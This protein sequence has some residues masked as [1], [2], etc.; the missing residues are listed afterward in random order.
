MKQLVKVAAL[1]LVALMALPPFITPLASAGTY[2]YSHLTTFDGGDTT[3]VLSFQQAG[4]LQTGVTMDVNSAIF[5]A[6]VDAHPESY[7]PGGLDYPINPAIDIG[8]DG[9]N[10]WAYNGIGYGRWGLQD[11]F[12][13]NSSQTTL[14]FY[15]P[16]DTYDI[17]FKV[18]KDAD[19]IGGSF[20]TGGWPVPYW[21]PQRVVSDPNTKSPAENSPVLLVFRGLLFEAWVSEDSTVTNN[22]NADI[23]YRHFDGKNWSKAVDLSWPKDIYWDDSPQ[24]VTF[25]GKLYCM[26]SA[27]ES[28]DF[29]SND[30]IL[31][32][33]TSDGNNWSSIQKISP[34][35]R[36]GMN[37]WPSPVVFQDKLYIV[38][39]TLDP[40]IADITDS[41]DMDLVYRWWDGANLGPIAELTKN[42]DG[43]MDWSFSTCAFNNRLYVVWETDT[44]AGGFLGP[45]MDIVVKSFDGISWSNRK[46]LSPD[47]DDVKDEIPG[48][49]VWYNPVKGSDELW[50]IW[51]RG[52]GNP[53]G[54]GDINIVVRSFDGSSWTPMQEISQPGLQVQNMGQVLINYEGRLYAIWVDGTESVIVS[55]TS[56]LIVYKIYGNIDIRSYDGY[57]WSSIK[58]LTPEQQTSKAS[59]PYL[60]VYDGRLFASWSFPNDASTSS[61]DWDII[62]RN[63][64]FQD[65]SL[66]VDVG[67]KGTTD[68]SGN[69]QSSQMVIPL[70]KSAIETAMTRGSITDSYGNQITEIVVKIRSRYPAKI[71]AHNLMIEYNYKKHFDFKD[72]LDKLLV[73]KRPPDSRQGL[74]QTADFRFEA[75]SG[76]QGKIVFDNLKID[77]LINRAPFQ[78]MDPPTIYL[79][80]GTSLP[81]ALDL[82]GYFSDDWDAGNLGFS[83]V[84]MD[85]PTHVGADLNGSRIGVT[86]YNDVWHGQ[87]NV[88]VVAIDN[89]GL[90]SARVKVHIVV[91]PINH[92]PILDFIPDQ[93]LKVGGKFGHR[94]KA[95]DVDGDKLTFHSNSTFFQIDPDTGQI[96]F[97][98][99]KRGVFKFNVSVDDGHGLEDSQNVTYT[100]KGESTTS[101]TG[102]CFTLVA[103]VLIAIAVFLVAWKFK[104]EFSWHPVGP[105][106]LKVGK[107][108]GTKGAEEEQQVVPGTEKGPA[109]PDDS[110]VE[111]PVFDME[112]V[113][114]PAEPGPAPATVIPV[115]RPRAKKNGPLDDKEWDR[116]VEDLQ[117]RKAERSANLRERAKGLGK[118]EVVVKDGEGAEEAP[119]V[120]EQESIDERPDLRVETPKPEDDYLPPGERRAR[121]L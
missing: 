61:K 72:Q 90:R 20:T 113:T 78:T 106:K 117:R 4:K 119:E 77:Y 76:S 89:F 115:V 66:D 27:A 102:T 36:A 32:R 31:M 107:G 14:Q 57:E 23:V 118:K 9:T 17:R 28:K 50:V 59:D 55:Q 22:S 75:F 19:I 15:N 41:N 12:N 94:C 105:E 52:D 38:W 13:D 95:Q 1:A 68:W 88:S 44:D 35:V 6:S 49:Y 81:D 99:T 62:L 87:S 16:N 80:A 91:L 64:D 29:F 46:A 51:G 24:L 97:T 103:I 39:K 48:T 33:W 21:G 116:V 25:Q 18:P 26:W 67:S 60:A 2:T 45:E 5:N 7:T 100:I 104:H 43:A 71:I 65:V 93:V 70:N 37:D 34:V 53:Q 54:T 108:K 40:N 86:T 98:S 30:D 79:K 112:D 11:V 120:L 121:G 10:D 73:S 47:N 82:Q 114:G 58:E 3:A 85:D 83:I 109:M 84:A 8:A 111:V 96:S 63:I 42:D 101:G 110:V 74:N 56:T 69:L 92:A